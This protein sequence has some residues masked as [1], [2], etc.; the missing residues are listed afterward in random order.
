VATCGIQARTLWLLDEIAAHGEPP[1]VKAA[2][3]Y[4]R[5]ALT[6]AEALGMRLLQA[7]CHRGLGTLYAKT[8][9]ASRP[10]RCCPPPLPSTAPWT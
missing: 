1:E 9:Q 2:E 8:G 5:Q 10:A 4:Y 7:H 3:A 6:L